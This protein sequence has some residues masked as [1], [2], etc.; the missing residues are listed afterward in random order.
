MSNYDGSRVRVGLLLRGYHRALLRFQRDGQ[1]DDSESALHSLFEAL[2]WA[3]ALDEVIAEIWR[4]AGSREG[5]DWRSRVTGAEVLDAVRYVRNRV[6]HQ[7]ADALR[8]EVSPS[9]VLPFGA[10]S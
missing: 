10:T 3:V 9:P 6:H 1:S 5:F 8:L 7:W 4:P 2:E